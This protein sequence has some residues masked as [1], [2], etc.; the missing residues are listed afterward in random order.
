MRPIHLIILIAALT[1]S[2]C[3]KKDKPLEEETGSTLTTTTGST[4]PNP[5]PQPESDCKDLPEPP[6]PFGWYD[7]TENKAKTVTSFLFD[8]VNPDRII[9]VI[10]GDESGYNKLFFYTVPTK[11]SKY[12]CTLGSYLPDVNKNGWITFSDVD[13]NIFVVKNNSDS[14]YQLTTYQHG[15]NPKW[16]NSG[17]YIYYFQEAFAAFNSSMIR[18]D[19]LGNQAGVFDMDL[20]YFTSFRNSFKTLLVENKNNAANVKIRD[21]TNLGDERI[22]LSGPM[23]S[24][25]THFNFNN[26]TLDKTDENFFWSNSY[27]IF[28]CNISS[29]KVDTLLKNCPN[30]IYRNPVISFK[31]NELTYT[32]EYI[33]V[34]SSYRLYH[35][36][37]CMEMNLTTKVSSEVKIYP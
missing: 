12:I 11:Q 21:F 29:L 1:V 14:V 5:E 4:N 27:G 30:Q 28:R 15:K 3:K 36:F 25:G 6:K 20:P 13:N 33:T 18:I 8:P 31:N 9:Y 16:D 32:R 10:N 2:A 17:S 26:L 19:V 22:L 7:S 24:N 37:K 34:L 23:Y 35:E